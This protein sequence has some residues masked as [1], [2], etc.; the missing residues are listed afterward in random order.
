MANNRIRRNAMIRRILFLSGVATIACVGFVVAQTET[1]PDRPPAPPL[2]AALD[3]DAD[4]VISAA[5]IEDAAT[6]LLTLD[7]NGDGQLTPDEFAPRD[8]G[9]PPPPPEGGG[10][11]GADTNGDGVVSLD[12]FLAGAEER[13]NRLDENGDGE[14]TPEE[15]RPPRPPCEHGGPQG[16]RFMKAD[17]DNDGVVSLDEFL[18]HAEEVFTRIDAN[19]DG[20]I[21]EE[22]AQ[23]AGPPRHHGPRGGDESGGSRFGGH[24]RGK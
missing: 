23:N 3:G 14:L 6:A 10:I 18:A 21:N 20:V 5:E 22:E 15:G 9:P 4:G 1:P 12:E 16:V 2:I 13:F 11:M 7:A 24:R 8:D 17:T 19:G